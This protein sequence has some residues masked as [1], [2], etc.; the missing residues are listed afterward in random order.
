MDPEE[1]TK[2]ADAVVAMRDEWLARNTDS[3]TLGLAT[4]LDVVGVEDPDARYYDCVEDAN[5]KLMRR[6]GPLYAALATTLVTYLG[7]SVRYLESDL[8]LPGFHIFERSSILTEPLDRAHF[9]VQHKYLRWPGDIDGDAL[10]SFTLP[11]RL[12][13]AGGGLETWDVT[14]PF[15]VAEAR[16]GRRRTLQEWMAASDPKR[17][18][19]R[20][21]MLYV[22]PT[23]QLHRIAAVDHRAD[24]DMRITL[25]GHGVRM[26]GAWI[27]YW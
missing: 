9:D 3:Y 2:Y 26:D 8:A 27:L 5:A 17:Y 14:E 25:Q 11:V 6:F 1:A 23:M 16:A 12:P 22:Q 15:A 21:G 24:D 10:I 13:Q 4:Y 19:Y 18:P 20:I 7:Q